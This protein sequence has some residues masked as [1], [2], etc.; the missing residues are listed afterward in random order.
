MYSRFS[1]PIG[2]QWYK[3]TH[4]LPGGVFLQNALA[5]SYLSY[6]VLILG[7]VQF[8]WLLVNDLKMKDSLIIPALPIY[9]SLHTLDT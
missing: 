1:Y 5:F 2:E 7:I 4:G 6:L 3:N 8:P 9:V